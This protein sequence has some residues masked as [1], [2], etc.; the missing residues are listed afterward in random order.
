MLGRMFG[1][2]DM[3][4]HAENDGLYSI[5]HDCKRFDCIL[6]FLRDGDASCLRQR[7]SGLESDLDRQ[8]LLSDIIF[9]GLEDVISIWLED[10][11]FATTMLKLYRVQRF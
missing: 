3:M 4:L 10:V 2:C 8:E 6:E 1:R 7:I 5:G 9:F 11:V